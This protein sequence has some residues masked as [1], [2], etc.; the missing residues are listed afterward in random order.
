MNS[1]AWNIISG[2]RHLLAPEIMSNIVIRGFNRLDGCPLHLV[3]SSLNTNELW[4]LGENRAN[5][6]SAAHAAALVPIWS[7]G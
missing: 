1:A 4:A 3:K 5:L 7:Y 6:V 2:D